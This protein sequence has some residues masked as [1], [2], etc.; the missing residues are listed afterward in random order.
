MERVL[1]NAFLDGVSLKGDRFFYQNPLMSCGDYDRFDWINT[2]CCPPNVVR[3]IASLGSYIYA[4]RSE[5]VYVGLFV[6]STARLA[7]GSTSVRLRQETRYPWDG[8]VAIHVDPERAKRFSVYIRIP[9]WT[10]GEVMPGNLYRFLDRS[11]EQ[12]TLAVNGRRIATAVTNG[13]AHRSAVAA[14]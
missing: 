2:P 5:D 6:D 11:R 7:A 3:L 9:G 4:T 13:F 12:V 1:Y 14:R 10:R 8:R